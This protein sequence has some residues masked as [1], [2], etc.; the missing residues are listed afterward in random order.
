MQSGTGE[1]LQP[2]AANE[3]P[4]PSAHPI[5]KQEPRWPTVLAVLVTG[6]LYAALPDELSAGPRWLLL[7]ILSVLV[8]PAIITHRRGLKTV[9]VV[10]GFTIESI[11]TIFLFWSVAMLV[12]SL[13]SKKIPPVELLKAA[14]AL[15]ICN[16]VLF[17]LWYWRLDAG[18]PYNRHFRG[19]HCSGAFLFPPMTEDGS[20]AA[21]GHWSPRF[22]DYL[23]LSFNT[24]TALSPTDAP[25]ISRWAKLLVMVQALTSLTIIVVLAA[26]AIN[27][28]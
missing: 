18:G 2:V 28:M 16:V 15:W 9:N 5:H 19:H 11:G 26:R 20:R 24:S 1:H 4:K 10:L 23:F 17:A 3:T 7:V 27:V 6:T 14:A 25:I 13:P 22:V 21:G 12:Q 8:I